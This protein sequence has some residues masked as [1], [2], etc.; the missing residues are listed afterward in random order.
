MRSNNSNEYS[1]MS[2]SRKVPV[3]QAIPMI[4]SYIMQGFTV[5]YNPVSTVLRI[6]KTL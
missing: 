5:Y 6:T 2:F 1:K 4:T 3:S